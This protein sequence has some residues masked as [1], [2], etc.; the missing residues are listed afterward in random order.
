MFKP[1]KFL[2]IFVMSFFLSQHLFAQGFGQN[3]VQYR[4]FDWHFLQTEHFD[5]YFYPGGYDIAVFTADVAEDAYKLLQRDFNYE[6]SKR[7]SIILYKSHNDFQQTN[8]VIPYMREGIGGVTELFKNRVVVPF[9]GSYSSFRHV[10]HHELVHAVMNDMLYGG[11]VQSL[12]SGQIAQV[13]TWFSEGL[14]EYFSQRWNTRTDMMVRDATIGGY[15]VGALPT[16]GAYFGGN[17]LFRYIAEK[18]GNEKIGEILHKIKGSFRFESAFKSALGIEL[19]DLAE[20]WQKQMRKEYWPDIADRLESKEFARAITDHHESKSY[21]NISPALSP[22]GDKVAF[23]SN[24]GGKQG[25]FIMDILDPENITKVIQGETDVNFEELHWLSPGMGWSPDATHLTFSAKAGDQDALYI[26]DVFNDEIEQ[27]K[28][29][30]DGLFSAAWS[31]NGDDIA[32][33]GNNNGAGD[34]YVFNLKSQKLEMITNDIFS[35]TYPRWSNDGNKIAFVSERGEYLTP[36]QVPEDFKMSNHNYE[37]TDIY[38]VDRYSKEIERIT[39]TEFLETDPVFSPNDSSLLYVSDVNGISNI[40]VHNLESG[41]FYPVSNLLSGAFQL[42]LDKKG[43]TLAFTSFNE[44]GFDL[45][46]I[47]NPFDLPKVELENTVFYNKL[48]DEN[49]LLSTV[50]NLDQQESQGDSAKTE[51]K[52]PQSTDYSNYVFADLNRKTRKE[53]VKVKLKEDDYKRTDGNFKIRNYKVKFSADIIQG[54]AQ[55]STLWGP[56]GFTQI[57]YSDVLGNHRIN[58]GTNLVFDLRNSFISAQYWYLPERIDYG[59]TAFHSA[60]SY[61]SGTSNSI[62]RFRNYG[63]AFIASRPFNKFSRAD[64]QLY[65]MNASLEYLVAGGRTDE[66]RSLVPSIQL[67]HD[68]SQWWGT[69]PNEGFRGSVSLTHSPLYTDK[70]LEFTT[71]KLDVRKYF[72]IHDYYSLAFRLNTGTS[73]GENPQLFYFGGTENWINRDF[74]GNIDS[75]INSVRDVY[76]SEFVTPVRGARFYEKT[77]YNFALVN[78]EVRFPLITRLDLGLPPISFGYIQGVLFSDVG[79]AWFSNNEFK[80]IEDGKVK[81]LFIGY[82]TGARIGIFGFLLKY[83]L[84][85]EYNL[86]KSS[87]AKHYFSIGVDI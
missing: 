86:K 14:A 38:I 87:R 10:I 78:S 20:N 36:E 55:Y 34:I 4:D 85:W 67:I 19:N 21:L 74:N 51:V 7:V 42:S 45:Y 57:A 13:P 17:S 22:N 5:I 40:Y 52:I 70:S 27:H 79:S 26:Y 6:L 32:F 47:K 53:K 49:S 66:V 84:A 31:P 12:I 68:T 30:I 48:E 43:H 24:M 41:E 44:I 59:V 75:R 82:G 69:G 81:D 65:M 76:F 2:H 35:D 25:I 3:K 39:D 23:L 80:G 61:Y 83:D 33:V 63:A 77:G 16:Y 71:L 1:R 60:H 9:E 8:V 15:L 46:T 62:I 73:F 54:Q 72:K 58:L 64:F 18:Y 29:D 28:F 50:D 37:N 56:E 11:S